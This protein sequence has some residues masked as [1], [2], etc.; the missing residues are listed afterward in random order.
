VPPASRRRSAYSLALMVV[1]IWSGFILVSR[2]GGASAMTAWDLFAIRYVTAAAILIP[3]WRY[4]RHP[5]LLDGR[6]LALTAIGGLAYGLLAFSG[7]KRS[8]ATHAA[9]LLPGLLPFA[10]AIA[11][12]VLLG[13]R[14]G[15]GRWAGLGLIGAGVAS[16]A[17]EVFSGNAA[18]LSGDLLLVAASACWAVYTVLLRRWAVAPLDATVAVT[19]QTALLYLPVYALALPRNLASVPWRRSCCRRFTRACSPAS[20]RCCCM[21]ELF[22]S[23]AR[24]A[25][26]RSWRSCRPS[27]ACWRCPCLA[28]PSPRRS[29]RAWCWSAPA[30]GRPTAHFPHQKG[31]NTALRQHP[32]HARWRHGCTESAADRRRDHATGRDSRQEPAH[33]RRDHRRS[34]DG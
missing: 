17:G 18:S 26:A 2:I 9:I 15:A 25:L 31:V 28:N 32:D 20:C 5:A 1:A 6:M 13:E 4:R 14:L 24:R 23:S 10:I 21:S 7:F 3:V 30:P 16:L 8:P 27:R 34:G 33:H 12:R 19:L 11:A 22:R 29:W